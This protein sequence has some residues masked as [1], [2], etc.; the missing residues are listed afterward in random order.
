MDHGQ[1]VQ[2]PNILFRMRE[3]PITWRIYKTRLIGHVDQIELESTRS[4]RFDFVSDTKRWIML[5]IEYMWTA[6]LVS[7][8]AITAGASAT[9][10]AEIPRLK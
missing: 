8:K 4:D 9:C 6:I 5:A 3:L 10:F 2:G 7:T 1:A